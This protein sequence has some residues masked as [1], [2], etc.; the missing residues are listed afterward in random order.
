MKR[1]Y[2]SL[3]VL[4]CLII[5]AL[6]TMQALL[7]QY[8]DMADSPSAGAGRDRPPRRITRPEADWQARLTP[9]QFNVARRGNTEEPHSGDYH[10][11]TATGVYACICC[12]LPLFA[13]DAKYDAGTG[14]PSFRT[15]LNRHNLRASL[16]HQTGTTRTRITCAACGARLGHLF[17]DGPP[18][19][20]LRYSMNSAAL[21]FVP[22]GD[23]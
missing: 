21:G 5:A 22:E 19:S 7:R 17:A 20:G 15:P 9:H 4:A 14:W 12:A 1:R 16:E 13:S 18:P 8:T 11:H 3:I 10:D 23:N 2:T 6:A